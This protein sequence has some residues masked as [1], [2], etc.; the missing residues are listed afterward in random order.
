MAIDSKK[1]SHRD[2]MHLLPRTIMSI[3]KLSLSVL[4]FT[5]TT[6]SIGMYPPY[7]GLG[8]PSR[9]HRYA[10]DLYEQQ[11]WDTNAT[12][13]ANFGRLTLRRVADGAGEMLHRT[14]IE[15]S[16]PVISAVTRATFKAVFGP[17]SLLLYGLDAL[18]HGAHPFK[19]DD[20]VLWQNLIDSIL[21][22]HIVQ[23]NQGAKA[24]RNHWLQE[25]QQQQGGAAVA[26]TRKPLGIQLALRQLRYVRLQIIA[27]LAFYNGKQRSYFA[28]VVDAIAARDVAQVAFVAQQALTNFDDLIALLSKI[29][30]PNDLARTKEDIERSSKSLKELLAYLGYLVNKDAAADMQRPGLR[31]INPR[32]GQRPGLRAGGSSLGGYGSSL[33]A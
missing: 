5:V 16:V 17:V 25:M 14:L 30:T 28:N 10:P 23:A 7:G 9:L 11:P 20:I 4:L 3:I 29:E 18:L 8:F 6:T 13:T 26:P 33:G 22:T 27:S 19:F 31:L 1:R 15:Q 24:I 21:E 2:F 32:I 12:W